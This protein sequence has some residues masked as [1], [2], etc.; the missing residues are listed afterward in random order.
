MTD[1]PTYEELEKRVRELEQTEN[2][3]KRTEAALC[4]S[5]RQ[6]RLLADNVSDM[7]WTMDM[8]QRLSYFSPSVLKFRGYTP[9]EALRI[10]IEKTLTPESYE[11]A[12]LAIMEEIDSEK[13]PGVSPD[14]SR[15]IE[16]EHIR[17]DG[18]T[19]WGEVTTSF[20]RD[21]EGLPY[22]IIGVTRDITQRKQA[23]EALCVS[24]KKYRDLFEKV[25]DILYFHDMEGNFIETNLF[26]K[27]EY[28]WNEN[29]FT[30]INIKSLIPDKYKHQF[31]DYLKEVTEKKE[32]TDLMRVMTK[33]GGD[34]FLKYN[35]SIVYDA[36]GIPIGVQGSAR[37]VTDRILA[38]KALR[39]S[40]KKYRDILE[41]IDDGY[42]EV[43]I[44]GKFTFFN[45]IM[46]KTLGYSRDDLI[47]TNNR[48]YLD[49]K[50]AEQIFQAFNT[51]YQTGMPTKAL[52]YQYIKKDGSKGFVEMVVSLITDSNN[53]GIGFR[54][55]ARDITDRKQLEAQLQQA[56]KMESIGTLAGGIA[57]DFNNLLY[58][59]TGN[60]ELAL[61]GIPQWNP[62]HDNL[63]EIKDAGM[64]AAGIVKQ[65]LS[66]SR[67]IDQELKPIGAI[68][69][70]KDAL[71][72]LRAMI[73]ASIEIRQHLP[74]THLPD[75]HLPVTDVSIL[76]DPV[77]INQV[78][79]NIC[80]NASQAM[81]ETGGNLTI[82]VEITSLT[83]DA[84]N[85]FP[86]LSAGKYVKIVIT[87]TGPGIDRKIIN[88]IF[89][90]YFTTKE[91]GKG[92]GMG[93]AVVAGII[94]NHSGGITVGS[95]PGKGATFTVL[96][97]VTAE[98]PV[99]AVA[100]P[101]E[102]LHGNETILFVDDEEAI[103]LMTQ[104]ILEY[105]G[106]MVNIRQNPIDALALFQSKPDAFDLVIT[107]MTMPQMTGIKLSEKLKKV[108]PDIPVIICTGHSSLI[109]DE[110]AKELGIA[111]FV[112]KP[113]FIKKIA[114]TIRQVLDD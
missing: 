29:D 57:H 58:M 22:G 91:I 18:S 113:I 27:K 72:F 28:G 107:D 83:Q 93:L 10:P 44:T 7:I 8:E 26:F 104:E 21:D 105:L 2:G 38:E 62:A 48:E 35:N 41:N 68:A 65:L 34:I 55:I 49:K 3:S 102:L 16:L 9:D 88:R 63:K 109:N 46:C 12:V 96:F 17:K 56:R 60:A 53:E 99:K 71:K 78:L 106:Y 89:D 79:M 94:K 87:D 51:V 84:A 70:I 100:P 4:K 108:R 36:H 114:K 112:M 67:K 92:S 39:K 82:N 97:P 45:D 14:R 23:E 101:D 54:G 86:D 24:E 50:N 20:L 76:A 98:N 66:F 43:D 85:H 69:V 95:Q 5:E 103:T 32:C 81:E 33:G 74:D 90:P 37:D 61:E 47:G 75:T 59:I 42:F 15:V 30:E 80:T 31:D 73:P 110:K 40:E 52:E 25:S 13:K 1:K 19:V 6:Y 64:R 111:A 77:Q 11:K